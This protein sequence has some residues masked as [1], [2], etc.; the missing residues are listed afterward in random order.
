MKNRS[1]KYITIIIQFIISMSLISFIT[2]KLILNYDDNISI[3]KNIFFYLPILIQ[4]V[5]YLLLAIQL[6]QLPDINKEID[7]KLLHI[8][9]ILLSLDGII[10]FPLSYHLDWVSILPPLL[11]GRIHLFVMLSS[12]LLFF[13]GG[14]H[15]NEA[16][17]TK[18]KYSPLFS[19]IFSILV[20]NLQQISS[21]I[22]N[23]HY[24]SIIPSKSYSL[25]V[26][27]VAILAIISYF[28]SYWNDRSIHNRIR[29]ISFSV[30][31]LT[32]TILR[33]YYLL[34]FIIYATSVI[35]L[36]LSMILYVVNIKSYTI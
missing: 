29:I 36:L 12:A 10:I 25:F 34:P 2:Y 23:L 8:N 14:L 18:F 1:F 31:I 4:E 26:I 6:Y 19:I 24:I 27:L 20:V 28:P 13:I 16:G 7:N 22:T 33:F 5:A 17:R 3:F 35:F 15:S 32:T 11:I 30:L 21:P 9:L